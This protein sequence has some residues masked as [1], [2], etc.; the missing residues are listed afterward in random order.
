MKSIFD[1]FLKQEGEKPEIA[2]AD[3]KELSTILSPVAK[4]N[5]SQYNISSVVNGNVELHFHVNSMESNAM[6]N[7]FK[8]EIDKLK[9]PD[10]V[11]EIKTSVLLT[12]FQAR[13]DI[14]SK[15][16]NKGVIEELSSKALNITFENDEIQECILHGN[17]NPFNTAYVVDVKI[18]TIQGKPV[19]YKVMKLHNSFDITE[20]QQN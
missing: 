13:N 14:N 18:Q 4:D 7:M 2:P 1:F 11:D 19:A 9:L 5:G 17:T 20:E 3:Y 6:Q 12:W 8:S 15:S 16:G 10:Q